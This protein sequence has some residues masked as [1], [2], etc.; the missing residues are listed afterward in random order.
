MGSSMLKVSGES[1]K[2]ASEIV[3]G[4]GVIVYP[5]DTVYG[6]G[7]DPFD[8]EAVARVFRLKKR[9]DKPLP[10]LGSNIEIL[11]EICTFNDRS[12]KLAKRFWPGALT[13]VLPAKARFPAAL[14]GD[15]IAV[16]TPGNGDT[17]E[18]IEAVGGLIVGTS[19]NISYRKPA[20]TVFEAHSQMGDSVDLFLDGG[21]LLG[22]PSTV[23]DLSGDKVMILRR[24]A[25]GSKEVFN[26]LGT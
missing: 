15:T 5:T 16:R 20:R 11:E 9:S 3:R 18:L 14:E 25:L 12:H 13:M 10:V 21:V 1:I 23:V 17:L 6:L 2:R 19:A 24:G 22:V 4:G 7:C 26:S 8:V